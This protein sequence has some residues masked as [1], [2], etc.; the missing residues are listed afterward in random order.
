[1]DG[2]IDEW[3][4]GWMDGCMGVWAGGLVDGWM[5][6]CV[7]EGPRIH[8]ASEQIR[9]RRAGGGWSMKIRLWRF[10]ILHGGRESI[11]ITCSRGS[12]RARLTKAFGEELGRRKSHSGRSGDALDRREYCSGGSEDARDQWKYDCG[13]SQHALD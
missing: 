4:D 2:R 5:Y 11:K 7:L 9:W 6:G 12:G 13:G 3:V 1:M 10:W 8:K